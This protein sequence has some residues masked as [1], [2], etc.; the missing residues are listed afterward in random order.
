MLNVPVE[1]EVVDVVES[2]PVAVVEPVDEF[3]GL[4]ELLVRED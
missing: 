1:V 2:L 3:P 4:P